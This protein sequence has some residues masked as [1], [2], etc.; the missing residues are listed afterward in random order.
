MFCGDTVLVTMKTSSAMM[1]DLIDWFGKG[2]QIIEK[3]K[4][5]SEIIISLKCNYNAMFYWALQYG[6]YVEILTPDELRKELAETIAAMNKK[7]NG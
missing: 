3:N 1:D 6:A 5:N 7:Y 2:F 4:E